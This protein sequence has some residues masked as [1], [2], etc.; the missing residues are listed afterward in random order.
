MAEGRRED[1]EAHLSLCTSA[2]R[3]PGDR[4]T[5]SVRRRSPPSPAALAAEYHV[6][7]HLFTLTQYLLGR[8]G[9]SAVRSFAQL[10]SLFRDRLPSFSPLFDDDDVDG[11]GVAGRY[12]GET[13]PLFFGIKTRTG[14]APYF[15]PVRQGAPDAPPL[16]SP[17]AS[18]VE[19]S[20]RKFLFRAV[21]GDRTGASL[22]YIHLALYFPTAR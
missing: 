13:H 7:S 2:V 15:L 5:L 19:R 18:H 12:T 16:A 3:H 22:I 6:A 8:I 4:S 1:R 14:H 11:D 21:T 9:E 20:S 17:I 10:A